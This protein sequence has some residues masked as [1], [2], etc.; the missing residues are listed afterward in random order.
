MPAQ[1]GFATLGPCRGI[2][3][4]PLGNLDLTDHPV[5]GLKI[6]PGQSKDCEERRRFCK[7]GAEASLGL[8]G[9][10]GF[11]APVAAAAGALPDA[12][13]RHHRPDHQLDHLEEGIIPVLRTES[14]DQN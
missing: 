9:N 10:L 2:S 13:V 5:E 8:R 14:S 1:T 7:A 3:G 11:V 6:P 12:A 4:C